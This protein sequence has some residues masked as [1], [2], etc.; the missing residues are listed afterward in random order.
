MPHEQTKLVIALN[1]YIFIDISGP[2]SQEKPKE[3][4]FGVLLTKGNLEAAPVL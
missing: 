3:C 2:Y 1:V 4:C